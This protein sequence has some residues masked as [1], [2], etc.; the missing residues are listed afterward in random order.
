[1]DY[2]KELEKYEILEYS[3][4]YNKLAEEYINKIEKIGV[5]NGF[6]VMVKIIFQ[7][8]N[9]IIQNKNENLKELI[10]EFLSHLTDCSII[11]LEKFNNLLEEINSNED[12]IE[13]KLYNTV[14]LFYKMFKERFNEIK[15]KEYRIYLNNNLASEEEIQLKTREL[16]DNYLKFDNKEILKQSHIKNLFPLL[17]D[18]PSDTK[19]K[20]SFP[21][22]P[23]D[24]FK[25]KEKHDFFEATLDN[26]HEY[27]S[28]M[29]LM[30]R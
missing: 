13:L 2:P 1:M 3:K 24:A 5:R 10:K 6:L 20:N 23:L 27:I 28:I 7:I 11:Y 18:L 25:K 15:E 4:E 26:D 14:I 22:N 19:L 12:N 30:K 16:K 29:N 17:K 9:L 21:K 8:K